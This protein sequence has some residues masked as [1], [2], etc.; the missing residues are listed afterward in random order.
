MTKQSSWI[1]KKPALSEA[2]A[3]RFAHLA[4]TK[5][6]ETRQIDASP[7]QGFFAG[8]GASKYSFT[9]ASPI[10]TWPS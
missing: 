8:G 6:S 4:M 1:A 2:N 3:A 10:S 9:V 5:G 7:V